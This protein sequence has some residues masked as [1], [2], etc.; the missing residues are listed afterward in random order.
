MHK[1]LSASWGFAPLTPHQGLCPWTP[2]GAPPPDPRLGLRSTRSPWSAPP[3][4]NPGSATGHGMKIGNTVKFNYHRLGN[5]KVSVLWKSDNKNHKNN[6]SI[7]SCWGPVPRSK[8]S[9]VKLALQH[10]KWPTMHLKQYPTSL[11]LPN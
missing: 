4:A 7:H 5:Q 10:E 8:N 11:T 3:L 6:D 2:S 1:K 9:P